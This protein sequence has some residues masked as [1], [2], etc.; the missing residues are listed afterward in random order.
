M[1]FKNSWCKLQSL[2]SRTPIFKRFKVCRFCPDLLDVD[3]LPCVSFRSICMRWDYMRLQYSIFAFVQKQHKCICKQATK[4]SAR[5]VHEKSFKKG[6][7]KV[8]AMLW[9]EKQSTISNHVKK[10][11]PHLKLHSGNWSHCYR[12][13]GNNDLDMCL[14]VLYAVCTHGMPISNRLF[15]MSCLPSMVMQSWMHNSIRQPAW[16]HCRE[17]PQSVT[18]DL[19]GYKFSNALVIWTEVTRTI[20]QVIFHMMLQDSKNRVR[21]GTYFAY[22]HTYMYTSWSIRLVIYFY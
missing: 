1:L 17:R 2:E 12:L 22:M 6:S 13:C 15:W 5:F 11:T 9:Y 19:T 3:L 21:F 16:A 8:F 14:H 7:C 4:R 10:D 18:V 20:C